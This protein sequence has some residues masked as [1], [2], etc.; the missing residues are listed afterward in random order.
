MDC[1]AVMQT[2]HGMADV[3]RAMI[4]CAGN[5]Y[6]RRAPTCSASCAPS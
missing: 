5:P 3:F 1:V 6:G 2:K 4:T